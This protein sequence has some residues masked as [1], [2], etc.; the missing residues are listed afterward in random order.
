[1]EVA[2]G[3]LPPDD[4]AEA[5]LGVP[6]KNSRHRGSTLWLGEVGVEVVSGG[7][8]AAEPFVGAAFAPRAEAAEPFVGAAEPFVGAAEVMTG[9]ASS[10]TGMFFPV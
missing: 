1:M 2:S 8:G 4:S 6:T 3:K 9:A 7:A 5:G 10:G